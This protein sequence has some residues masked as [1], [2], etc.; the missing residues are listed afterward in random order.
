MNAAST[1]KWSPPA[2]SVTAL[3]DKIERLEEEILVLQELVQVA[4]ENVQAL[5]AGR[6]LIEE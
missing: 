4:E 6:E 1:P 2:Y 3:L 5:L